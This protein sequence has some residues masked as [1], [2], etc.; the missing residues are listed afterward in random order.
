M[1]IPPKKT[2]YKLAKGADNP[3]V[4]LVRCVSSSVLESAL[5]LVQTFRQVGVVKSTA[6]VG[7]TNTSVKARVW[8]RIETVLRVGFC[9][10]TNEETSA[11]ARNTVEPTSRRMQAMYGEAI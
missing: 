1:L 5:V 6:A 3:S 11:E 8:C 10:I 9:R 2:V 4:D 7:R